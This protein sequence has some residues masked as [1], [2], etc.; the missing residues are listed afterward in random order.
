MPHEYPGELYHLGDDLAESRNLYGDHPEKVRE[1]KALLERYKA[2][3]RSV[4]R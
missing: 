3:G 2:E 4:W 1:L